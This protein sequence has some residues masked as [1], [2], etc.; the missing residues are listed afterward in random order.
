MAYMCNATWAAQPG[1]GDTVFGLLQKLAQETRRE[2]GNRSYDVIR[3]GPDAFRIV[4]VYDDMRAFDA[5]LASSHFIK[6]AMESAM[7]LL[8]SR[9]RAVQETPETMNETP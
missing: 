3:D 4:E 8:A 1:H 7:P 9:S 6:L 5:H 2:R